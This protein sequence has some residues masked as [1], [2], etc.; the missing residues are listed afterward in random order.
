M[1]FSIFK[2]KALM[3][4]ARP[5]P[6]TDPI[7]AWVVEIGRPSFDA[8]RIVNAAPNSAAKPRDGVSSVIFS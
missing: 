1:S 3:P 5:T 4:L 8:K 7:N 2:F 6:N